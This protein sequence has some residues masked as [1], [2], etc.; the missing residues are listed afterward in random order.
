MSQFISREELKT[1]IAS[2]NKQTIVEALPGK[3]YETEHLPGAIN[4]PHDEIPGTAPRLIADKNA[5]VIVYCAN[6]ECKNSHIAAEALRKLGYSQVY[7][8]PEGKSGWK[9][10]GLPLEM[11]GGV[12]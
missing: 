10:A 3:Y 6:I 9:A 1:L 8:Y 5:P 7:E 2:G 12:K 11:G 4:I